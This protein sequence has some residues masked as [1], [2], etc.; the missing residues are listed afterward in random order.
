[1]CAGTKDVRL[2]N[3]SA[4]RVGTI[5]GVDGRKAHPGDECHPS[6]G[7]VAWTEYER[8]REGHHLLCDALCCA[9][10]T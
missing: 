2:L 8:L 10:L 4:N 6:K 1:M 7:L 9:T 5:L 3:Q